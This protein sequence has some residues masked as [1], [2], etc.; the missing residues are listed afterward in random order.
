[1]LYFA[2]L[3]AKQWKINLTDKG[4]LYEVTPVFNA[5]ATQENDRMEFFR[6]VSTIDPYNTLWNYYGTGNQ[7]KVQRV[8]PDINNRIFGLKDKQFPAF[9]SI[10]GLSNTASSSLKNSSCPTESDLGWYVDLEANERIT[11]ALAIKDGKVQAVRYLPNK[12]DLCSPGKSY[13]TEHNYLC[14]NTFR[15][16]YLGEGISTG[17]VNFKGKTY[18]GI[19]GE[20]SGDI[21]DDKGKVVGKLTGEGF[22]LIDTPEAQQQG[23]GAGDIKYESWREVF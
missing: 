12:A 8:S 22:G 16:I 2:D 9:Q 6:V 11:G 21:K 14:G 15:R 7:Q 1:M 5:E 18:F 3:E 13:Y 20:T 19:T 4:T 10:N 17:V 23:P